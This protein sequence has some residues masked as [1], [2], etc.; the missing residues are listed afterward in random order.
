MVKAI[1]AILIILIISNIF[2]QPDCRYTNFSGSFTFEEM[3]FKERN[4]RMCKDKFEAFKNRNK[5]DTVLY[6]LC[7]KNYFKFW[8]YRSYFF[9]EQF[10]LPFMRWKQVEERRGAVINKSGFQDF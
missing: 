8:N 1:V 2:S 10:R 9:S 7:A 6:R 4:F 3:N 5:V